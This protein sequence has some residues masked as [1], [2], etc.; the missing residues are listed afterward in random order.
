MEEGGSRSG[1]LGRV[2]GVKWDG[3]SKEITVSAGRLHGASLC[4]A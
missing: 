1:S 3:K 4:V 2:K